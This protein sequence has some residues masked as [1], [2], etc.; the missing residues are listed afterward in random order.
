MKFSV[1]SA[2][3]AVFAA[4]TTVLSA[5]FDNLVTTV[6]PFGSGATS[7]PDALAIHSQLQVVA[8]TINRSNTDAKATTPVP[9]SDSDGE[10]ILSIMRQIEPVQMKAVELLKSKK[11]TFVGLVP[12]PVSTVINLPAII[13]GD[14][15]AIRDAET[16][17]SASLVAIS[18]ASAKAE[19]K[20]IGDR[21]VG[22]MSSLAQ[23]Y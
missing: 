1:A 7:V 13:K 5:P 9:L 19:I 22:S 20:A 21:L 18:G 12:F 14:A 11:T 8:A 4:A 10:S 17:L 23:F 15:V 3:F 16:V 2:V 6:A